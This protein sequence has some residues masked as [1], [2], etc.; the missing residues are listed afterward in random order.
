MKPCRT[1]TTGSHQGRP[2]AHFWV[3]DET[4]LTGKACRQHCARCFLVR[5]RA[6]SFQHW[7]YLTHNYTP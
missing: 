1:L 2:A 5:K 4:S 6:F 3:T 7:L